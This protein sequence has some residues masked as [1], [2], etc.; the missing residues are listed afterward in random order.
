MLLALRTLSW[1]HESI[2]V[3]HDSIPSRSNAP[4]MAFDGLYPVVS[5][6]VADTPISLILDS[7]ARATH[8]W[9]PLLESLPHLAALAE[10]QPPKETHGVGGSVKVDHVRL[11]TLTM[12]IGARE[13]TLAPAEIHLSATTAQSHYYQGNLGRDI[14]GQAT[15]VRMDF[16]AMR[17]VLE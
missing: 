13:M 4:N 5:A 17:L 8:L 12:T 6:H 16:G 2:E 3:G 11:R 14:L 15:R 7:G 1:S 10:K 9:K